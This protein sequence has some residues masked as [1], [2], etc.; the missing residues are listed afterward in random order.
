MTLTGVDPFDPVP[1]DRREYVLG[2]GPVA[3]GG[4]AAKVMLYA[5]K[6]AGASRV[7]DGIGDATDTVQGPFR[8]E[9]SV[10][11][12]YGRR[13]EAIWL[14][15]MFA[16]AD[17]TADI[18]ITCPPE[19]ASGAAAAVMF[20]F[21]AGAAS[22]VSS[23]KIDWGGETEYVTVSEGD[24]AITQ[25]ANFVT[26]LTG[27]H[28]GSWPFTAAIGGSGSEHIVTVTTAQLGTRAHLALNALRVTY[29]KPATTTCTKSSV[30]AGTGADDHTAA[31][32]AAVAAGEFLQH[33][34]P[35]HATSSV[36]ATDNQIGELIAAIKT[37]ALPISGKDQTAWFGL[38]GTQS[39]AAAVAQ[40]SGANTHYAHFFHAE[41]SPWTPG[42]LAAYHAGIWRA[43][44]ISYPAS[45]INGYTST[46]QQ[47]YL[48]P[49]PYS[50]DDY[51]SDSEIR[52][53]IKAGV[54]PVAYRANGQSYLVRFVNSK[55]LNAAGNVDRRG[56]EGHT[57][58]VHYF[59][60]QALLA[61]WEA[62]RQPNVADEL[63]K[64]TIPKPLTAYPSSLR[65]LVRRLMDDL[66]GATPLGVYPGP[67]LDPSTIEEQKESVVARKSAPGKLAVAYKAKPIEHLIGTETTAYD[68]SPTY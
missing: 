26:A 45:N 25:A 52:A 32:A 33:I 30:T 64:G 29:T 54:C 9:Q 34:S 11:D 14:Y 66:A 28:E 46:S 17:P 56:C 16:T 12:R 61:R 7:L 50:K 59:M 4:N 53:D 62:Q 58:F 18:Y 20:T 68:N 38:V 49:A 67:I 6:T 3:S 40:S 27:A 39:Q 60:W 51:P 57:V 22:A 1:A 2:A 65:D 43:K 48:V 31:Y 5:N 37:Q 21:A 47:N 15:R 55:S 63:P 19:N 8:D 35:C 42:M 36:T 24:V 10:I 13:S 44:Y 23:L 41:N